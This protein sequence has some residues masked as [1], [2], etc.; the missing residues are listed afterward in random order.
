MNKLI[1]PFSISTLCLM[2]TA[3]GGGS[4]LIFEDPTKKPQDT[5]ATGCTISD[6]NE[7]CFQ[8]TMEYPIAGIQYTCSSDKVNVFRTQIDQNIVS[9]GCDKKDTATFFL[10]ANGKARIELGSVK[11]EDLGKVSTASS[12]VHLSVLDM[13]RGLTGKAVATLDQ[14]DETVKMAMQLIKIFQAVGSQKSDDNIIGDIQPIDMDVKILE[15]LSDITTS[16]NTTEYQ[17]GQYAAILKP[18]VDVSQIS[19]DEAFSVLKK[20]LNISAGAIY[21]ADP[22]FLTSVVDGMIGYSGA[23]ANKKTF[24]GTFFVMS[25]R[26]GFSHGYGLHWRGK[27]SQSSE[28]SAGSIYLITEVPPMMMYANTQNGLINPVNKYIAATDK[29]LFKTSN[30]ENLYLNSGRLI[31][32]YAVAGTDI[33]YKYLTDIAKAP[34]N[35]LAK[36][37]MVAGEDNYTGHVDFVKAYPISYLDRR[38]FKSISNVKAGEK[39]YFPLYATLTFNYGSKDFEP[40]KLGIVIDENG[41]IRTDVKEWNNTSDLSGQC[42]QADATLAEPK[43]NFG[44]QQYRIGTIGGANYQRQQSDMGIS[45]RIILSGTQFGALDGTFVGVDNTVLDSNGTAAVNSNGARINLYSLLTAADA[46]IGT[47]NISS[48]SGGVA[49]W[50]NPYNQYKSIYVNNDKTATDADKTKLKNSI[51]GTLSIQLA[52]CYKPMVK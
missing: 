17:N 48:Y 47:I 31:N 7:N 23:D 44:V 9:G 15:G 49:S 6:T 14:N 45:P 28:T 10:N 29:F 46:S 1:L 2:M 43:D 12:P 50:A 30:N 18:W 51:Y 39:Y 36:W 19:D 22:P 21:Q 13:A 32:D 35:D 20:A 33:F 27:P 38:V 8:F 34:E 25:D 16:I 4:N 26:Q 24:M 42:G 5:T 3:C 40:V 37:S 11:I 41:D 52:S